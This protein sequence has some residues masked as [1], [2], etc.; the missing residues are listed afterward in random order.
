MPTQ[1]V[2]AVA[3]LLGHPVRLGPADGVELEAE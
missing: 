3:A 2:Q 1:V